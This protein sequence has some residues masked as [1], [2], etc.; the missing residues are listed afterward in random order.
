MKEKIELVIFDM[1]GLMLD[2]EKI[3]LNAW[4]NTFEKFTLAYNDS[5]FKKIIGSDLDRLKVI[6]R[7]E[8][9][10]NL[11]FMELLEHQRK[12]V[13]EIIEI[14][15]IDIKFGLLDLLEYLDKN[16]IKKAVATSTIKEKAIRNLSITDL[17]N[18]FDY[19][20]CGDEVEKRKPF[21]DLYLNV[22]NRYEIKKDNII[23]LEDSLNGL[24][25]AKKSGIRCIY[26]PDLVILEKDEEEKF[27]FKKMEN[28]LKVK[29]YLESY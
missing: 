1:D 11:N 12:K 16:S 24:K 19:I 27:V 23:I 5:F 8:Y 22:Y 9:G 15:G 18:R 20:I 25:A 14:D 2:T 4:K 26:I 21:P 29:E 7:D 3:S 17:I 10:E 13:K 28:L 6:F